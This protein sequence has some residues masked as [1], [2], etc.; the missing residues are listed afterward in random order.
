MAAENKA[1]LLKSF[2]LRM[3]IIIV[4]SSIIGSGIFK[5]VAPMSEGLL[6]PKL[7]ILAWFLAGV[8]VIFGLFSA[9]ELG[10][11]YPH[12]GGPFSWLEKIYGKTISF[13]YGWTSFTV[14]QTATVASVSFISAGALNTFVPLPHLPAHLETITIWGVIQPFDNMGAKVVA[15][16]MIVLLTFINIRGAKKGGLVSMIFTYIIGISIIIIAIL[17]FNSSVG[18][19]ESFNTPSKNFPVGGFGV[20]GFI[21]V[22]IIAMRNAF[23]GYEGWLAI[24]FLGEEI[25]QPERNFPKAMMIG[26]SLTMLLYIIINTGY[27]YVVPIDELIAKVNEDTNNI[28]AVVVVDKIFGSS[29]AYIIS[30]MILIST[31]GC[32]NATILASSRI[33]YAMAQ[34]GLFFKGAEICHPRTHTPKNAL[35]YQAIWSCILVISGSFDFLS[36]LVIIAAFMFYGLIVFGV[37]LLRKKEPNAHRPYKAFGYPILPI[38]F[39]LFCL[40]LLIISFIETPEQSII[41]LFLVLSGLP[42]FYYW[43]RKINRRNSIE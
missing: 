16:M 41:G 15:M 24:G 29:G 6:D 31:L 23:W 32:T 26:L 10:A 11:M 39:T 22:L 17:A 27:L 4:M 2:G 21:S 8:V 9:A 42:F 13:L 34:K 28:A 7:V 40:I 38:L 35:I 30:A 14:I 43:R 33:Y 18:S 12:S 1:H 20:I 5:K 36:D 25:K 19:W 3:G 37:I